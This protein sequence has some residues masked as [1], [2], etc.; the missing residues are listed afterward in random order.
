MTLIILLILLCSSGRIA[1]QQIP[2]EIVLRINYSFL[3]LD[4]I[5]DPSFNEFTFR[6]ILNREGREQLKLLEKLYEGIGKQKLSKIFGFMSWKDSVSISRQGI[7]VSIPPFWATFTLKV[8]P[9]DDYSRL[10]DFLDKAIPLIDYA[11]PSFKVEL[12]SPPNDT[13]YYPRQISLSGSTVL[14]FAGINVEEAW[15]IETGEP[16]I[17]VGVL[18]SGIDAAHPDL[19]VLYGGTYYSTGG[20]YYPFGTDT[21]MH[22][23]DVAGIIAAKRNNTIGIAGIAGGNNEEEKGVSLI[24]LK[25]SFLSNAGNQYIC[26]AVV[27][28][29]RSVGTY[30]N[31]AD[32][33][34]I[35][36]VSEPFY[37]NTNYLRKTPGFGV[38]ICNNS[39][40][41]RIE[42][43]IPTVEPKDLPT[44]GGTIEA[45]CNLCRE[46]FLFSLRSGVI[47]VVARGNSSALPG[48]QSPVYAHTFYP[49][50][51]PDGW[52]V[53]VGASGYDGTTVRAGVNQSAGEAA[54]GYYSLYGANMDLV[55]PGSDSIVHATKSGFAGGEI[56]RKFNGTSA[57][58]PHVSGVVA[59]LLSHYN[60]DCYSRRNLSVEDVEYILQKSATDVL[61]A[62]FDIESGAGRLDAGKALKMIQFPHKQI[63][64][65]DSLVSSLEVSRDTIALRNNRAFVAEKWGPVSR[66]MKLSRLEN[67]KVVRVAYENTYSF[68]EYISPTTQI[69][70]YWVRQSVSN[71]TRQYN[72][73]FS[74]PAFPGVWQ[75]DHFDMDPFVEITE[76]NPSLKLV[77]LRGYYYH[78]IEQYLQGTF[79]PDPVHPVDL[80]LPADPGSG[81]ARMGF[82]LYIYDPALTALYDAPCDSLSILFDSTYVPVTTGI[83]ELT[84]LLPE[85]YPNPVSETLNI[86]FNSIVGEKKITLQDI[87]GK[88][89]GSWITKDDEFLLSMTNLSNGIYVLHCGAAGHSHINKIIKL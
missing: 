45:N 61:S 17:K 19:K 50:A 79:I 24:D 46:A 8:S 40:V 30:W 11:E 82:S 41:M 42:S 87:H 33:V 10:L 69:L 67:F 3:D 27:D 22:G 51:F 2:K 6:E 70:D 64:H 81:E 23:T 14:P 85:V 57:A 9:S 43:P 80:W 58:A 12:L 63:V 28:A 89:I 76:W 83:A 44:D 54:S 77:K 88:E 29:A 75:F 25:Y 15:E 71:S 48:G 66:S 55:A 32:S 18:D 86:R 65:P 5:D 39:Y 16:F 38:H 37:N 26:A 31:Y 35:Y 4:L 1:A 13:L 84:D 78:F 49:Q 73:T 52:I 72:D 21:E 68:S 56:Y 34:D 36:N 7:K 47:N 53:S 60:S 74:T 20:T 62:G 59:L